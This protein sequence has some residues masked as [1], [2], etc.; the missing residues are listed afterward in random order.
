MN[1]HIGGL[2]INIHALFYWLPDLIH[3]GFNRKYGLS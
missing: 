3:E 2:A 1:D